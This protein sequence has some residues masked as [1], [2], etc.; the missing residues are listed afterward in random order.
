MQEQQNVSFAFS[1]T[2]V[3]ARCS[4]Y[5]HSQ[6][7]AK[8]ARIRRATS[9]RTWRS[10]NHSSTMSLGNRDC[11]ISAAFCMTRNQSSSAQSSSTSISDNNVHV[12]IQFDCINGRFQAEQA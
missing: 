8:Q 11:L 3:H 1:C 9:E 4:S 2:C 10:L 12:V 7:K 5:S 6:S